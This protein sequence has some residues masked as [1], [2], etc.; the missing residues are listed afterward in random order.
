[1]PQRLP[2]SAR[3][4]VLHR[5]AA[6][7][8]ALAIMAAAVPAS[9]LAWVGPAPAA[10]SVSFGPSSATAWAAA[11]AADPT[12]QAIYE[13][14]AQDPTP[15]LLA[16][17]TAVALRAEREAAAAAS[18]PT[19]TSEPAPTDAPRT[20]SSRTSSRTSN[21]TSEPAPKKTAPKPSPKPTPKPTPKPAPT[22][23][24]RNH[25]WY[26][27]LGI[28][29]SVTWYACSASYALS[30]SAVYRWGCAGT[31][32]VYLMAH[33][34]G[35]FGPLYTAY[36]AGKLKVG[37]LV[38]YADNASHIHYFKLQ[39]WKTTPPDGDVGWAY[40]AQSVSSLTLQTCVGADSSLRLV[41]RFVEV[42]KP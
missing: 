32:N 21:T 8:S 7:V 15:D 16:A 31:N 33:A 23:S 29:H 20:T 6:V 2:R 41:A 39:W 28:S 18:G 5:L 14:L 35:I 4:I 38:V 13:T 9:A 34:G 22:Y 25:M 17:R 26:P 12:G 3:T 37:M 27:A 10:A 11:P 40:A 24:G 42:A 1:M 36:Y 30:Y 19:A